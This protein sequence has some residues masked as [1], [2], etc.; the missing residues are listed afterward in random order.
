[1]FFKLLILFIYFFSLNIYLENLDDTPS[2]IF[3]ETQTEITEAV[4]EPKPEAAE[5]IEEVGLVDIEV[6]EEPKPEAAEN[7]EEV[8]L[9][10]IEV[11]EEPE[12]EA[13][14]IIEEVELDEVENFIKDEDSLAN[15]SLDILIREL[16]TIVEQAITD[17]YLFI[18]FVLLLF[19]I[20]ALAVVIYMLY[21][22]IKWRR[23]YT[24]SE[25]V[26]FK[27]THLDFLE[28]LE[29]WI[30]NTSGVINENQNIS[31]NF[32]KETLESLQKM[33]SYISSQSNELDRYKEGYDFSIKKN[34]LLSLVSIIETLKATDTAEIKDPDFLKRIIRFVESH[35]ENHDV[36]EFV[37]E[38]GQSF[39]SLPA[40]EFEIFDTKITQDDNL[41]ESIHKTEESGY[42]F[43]FKGGKQVLK[44]AKII[45]YKT[46]K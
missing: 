20:L 33:N 36:Q 7:I 28:H 45:I 37:F 24:N 41:N 15:K 38:Q 46:E 1:M 31:M 44:R 10:D 18:L 14:E 34:V 11:I 12:P 40:D 42:S 27:D 2:Q 5:N 29:K 22:Q 6:I 4:E 30:K 23:R 39:R 17:S 3:E 32:Q 9:V 26:V 35:L 16:P 8:E 21:L 19:L 43:Y 13:A 25:S